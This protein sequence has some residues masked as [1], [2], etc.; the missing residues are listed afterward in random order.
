[1][2]RAIQVKAE[3]L[4]NV[5]VQ[6]VKQLMTLFHQQYVTAY[7]D[8][9]ADK[10]QHSPYTQAMLNVLSLSLCRQICRL[11]RSASHHKKVI[12][13][14]CDNTLWGGAVAEVGA[15]GIALAP[16]FLALQ[17]FIVAQQ[18]RGMLIA[19]C[20]KN[21]LADVT[22]AF[23]QRRGDMILKIDQHV[24]AVKANWQ[25]KSENITQLAEELSLGK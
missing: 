19:L 9:V 4:R 14:D 7:Y 18:E 13:L 22:E 20:S 8:A 11:L 21:M 5:T 23:T 6:S 3:A 24:S 17:R 16:R 2:E 25:P 12:V 15:S 1:M 10:L